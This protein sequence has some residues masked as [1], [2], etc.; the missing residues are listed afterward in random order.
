MKKYH[1]YRIIF[2]A[3]FFMVPFLPLSSAKAAPGDFLWSKNLYYHFPNGVAVGINGNIYVTDYSGVL[4]VLSGTGEDI[5]SIGGMGMP[6]W[7]AA[8]DAGNGNIYVT[9]P[10]GDSI[11]AVNSSGEII[12]HFGGFWSWS[13]RF[14]N[15]TGVAVNKSGVIY[16]STD[17]FGIHMFSNTGEHLGNFGSYGSGDGQ[18]DHPMGLAADDNGNV[19]VADFFNNR[20][21]VFS[22]NG[23]FLRQWGGYGSGNGQF[24]YPIGV[25]VDKFGNVYVVELFNN[26]VQV[27]DSNGTFLGKWGG[28]GFGNGQ[29]GYPR[30]I[31]VD[32]YNRVYVVSDSRLQVFEGYGITANAGP[33]QTIEQTSPQGS[34]VTLDGSASKGSPG[35]TL[36][37]Q[38][39]WPGGSATGVNPTVLMP[40]GT[41]TVTLT[42]K[43]ASSQAQAAVRITVQDTRKPVATT[44]ISGTSGTNGWY[45][46]NIGIYLTAIDSGSGVRSIHIKIDETPETVISGTSAF[47]NLTKEGIHTVTY[48]AEDNAGNIEYSHTLTT[49]I[50][51]TPP[52]TT[53]TLSGK[54]GSGGC[55]SS[56][57]N[58]TLIASDAVSGVSSTTYTLDGIPWTN[59]SG[60]F[61]AVSEGLHLLKYKSTDTA[62][63]VEAEKN[64]NFTIDKTPPETVIKFDT[65]SKEIKIY[66]SETGKEA[67]YTV[68]PSKSETDKEEQ[69]QDDE[70]EWEIR[71]YIIKDCA[72]NTLGLTLKHKKEGKEIK[73]Q[74]LTLQYNK[75]QTQTL[76][77][78]KLQVEYTEIKNGGY[79]EIEQE[80]DINNEFKIESRYNAK[81]DQTDI[82]IETQG[83]KE[84]KYRET[85]L[86]ILKLLTN[87]GRLQYQ[88]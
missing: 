20:I 12:G 27:F 67:N 45:T 88:Y 58:T 66:N 77:K 17:Y 84:R 3:L 40:P 19:Y 59:Y 10:W 72:D 4:Q 63:N 7:G 62:G 85:G 2:T 70:K 56:D 68:L 35:E 75:D 78:N 87:K 64:I 31:A 39:T 38:W 55:Y 28:F 37:Y 51:K 82:N 24:L 81:K 25:A 30:A 47:V 13:Y 57:V 43:N 69:D 41:T 54:L 86:I 21:E 14:Y 29:F 26:R 46:S 44:I 71:Q 34:Y 52:L 6:L 83:Q 50:D 15:P 5:R 18:F 74:L 9:N 80:I 8:S 49:K 76:P 79:K 65:L 36:T 33:D 23:T 73:V 61:T 22:S 16:A 53:A 48:Y 42:V 1:L 60:I 11:F 32:G